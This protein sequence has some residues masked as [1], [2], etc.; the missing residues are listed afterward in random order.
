[1]KK[2]LFLGL[3][4]FIAIAAYAQNYQPTPLLKARANTIMDNGLS[5]SIS[6]SKLITLPDVKS[7]IQRIPFGSSFNMLTLLEP[8]NNNCDYNADLGIMM[9]THRAGGA[10]G[11]TSGDIRCCFTPYF[12][13]SL[14]TAVFL[15]QGNN[16]MRYPGGAIYNPSGNITLAN[17]MAIITGPVT[18][19]TNWV[20]NYF[21]TQKLNGTSIKYRF[22]PTYDT[23]KAANI[24]LTV[25]D[26]GKIR[27]AGKVSQNVSGS[28]RYPYFYFR[29][30]QVQG[31]SVLWN[32]TEYKFKNYYQDRLFSNDTTS[33][34]FSPYMAFSNDG[35]TGYFYV[36]GLDAA[37]Y[38]I[39]SGPKPIVWKTID[40]GTTWTK[41][42][43]LDLS[44]L[45]NKIS[46]WIKPTR[47][48]LYGPNYVYRP[49]IMSGATVEE[50]NFPGIVDINGNLH[51]ACNI[52][53]MFSSN[54]DSLNYTYQYNLWNIFDLHT[55]STGWDV[56]LVDTI[57]AGIDKGIIF[58]D[59]YLD[60]NYHI[61]KNADGSKIFLMWTDTDLDTSN[62]MPDIHARAF[63]MVSGYSTPSKKMTAQT[64]YY[65]F[66]ASQEV[67]DSSGTYF[68]PA[69]FAIIGGSTGTVDDEP[70]HT[71]VK[72][73]K[74]SPAEFNI[75]VGINQNELSETVI[76]NVSF[77]PN[78]AIDHVS[79]NF[80]I[81]KA[82]NVKIS[83]F[84]LLGKEVYNKYYGKIIAGESRITLNTSDLTSGIY[85]FTVQAGSD[86]IT[87]K[88]VIE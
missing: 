13:T 48:T 62:Y 36:I 87:K 37:D 50:G 1:M 66:N 41:L 32:A 86:R 69:T 85:F 31:D 35:M 26:G 5:N 80:S 59:Q 78:P 53:G 52:E 6:P 63:D 24:N 39:N 61:A 45:N 55:T 49:G 7:G 18:D 22:E 40:G 9:F 79:I 72:G 17:A 27:V 57:H 81:D 51:I 19:G 47:A 10:Y 75:A 74:F 65:L 68:M 16:R 28:L 15:Q 23:L 71:F 30:G 77:N 4:A 64:D 67:V 82:S 70:T 88:I 38:A 3:V 11:G 42:P 76:D 83:I 14:S 60:H 33:W 44:T 56:N 54:I 46:P 12:G 25:C 73:L 29:S 34:A 58:S 8:Y 20:Y 21:C 2:K 43:L 84:N